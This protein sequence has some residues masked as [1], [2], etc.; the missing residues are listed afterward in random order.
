MV[1]QQTFSKNFGRQ[2]WILWNTGWAI[3]ST[4]EAH[5]PPLKQLNMPCN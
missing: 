4:G 2:V 3:F 5:A 1:V